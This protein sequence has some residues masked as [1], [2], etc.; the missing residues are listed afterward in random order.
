MPVPN[1]WTWTKTT[2]QKKQFFSSNPRK[3]EVMITF[4]TN[5]RVTKLWSHDHIHN[6]IWVMWQNFVGNVIDKI[7]D[8]ITSISRFILRRP[9]VAIA[10]IIK[11][12]IMLI[13]TIYKDSRKV[14][15]NRKYISK[16]N[17]YMNLLYM[18]GWQHRWIKTV[19]NFHKS[20]SSQEVIHDKIILKAGKTQDISQGKRSCGV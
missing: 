3:I 13:M 10:D 2:P 1:Y 17:L 7:Y 5:A 16:W 4:Y 19:D 12:L 9:R 15:I 20:W 14:K 11:I 6:I 18:Y 8:I